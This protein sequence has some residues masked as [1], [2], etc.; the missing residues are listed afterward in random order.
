MCKPQTCTQA[1]AECGL[2]GDGCGGVVDCGK[3][4]STQVCGIKSPN[5]CNAPPACTPQTCADVQAECGS[6]GD[7][8]GGLVDCGA[9]APHEVCGAVVANKCTGVQ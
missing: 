9:C 7:G 4:I 3:C 2:I 1:N 8:C 5:K 6:I